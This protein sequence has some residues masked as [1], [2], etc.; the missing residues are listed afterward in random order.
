MKSFTAITAAL[1]AGL[2]V[3]SPAVK[4]GGEVTLVYW[5]AA[6]NT[7]TVSVPI[8]SD[9]SVDS[10]LSFSSISSTSP[11]NTVCF[12]YGVDGSV[13]KLYG[14]ESDVEIGPPQVQTYAFCTYE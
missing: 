2:V 9:V 7:F 4:R 5:A 14:S 1:F 6:D 10:D 8:G 11:G 13:T 3:A 12:S